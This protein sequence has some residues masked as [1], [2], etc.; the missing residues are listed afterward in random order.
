MRGR[1][2]KV[3]VVKEKEINSVLN[4]Q[5]LVTEGKGKLEKGLV[6]EK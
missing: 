1:P 5:A 3:E 2:K 4:P 6:G